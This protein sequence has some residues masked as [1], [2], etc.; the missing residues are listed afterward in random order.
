MEDPK[1]DKY[2][3]NVTEEG[4]PEV[5][6]KDKAMVDKYVQ[7]LTELIHSPKSRDSV[8]NTITSAPDPFDVVPQAA[9]STNDMGVSLMKQNGTEIGFGIQLSASTFLITELIHLGYAA[10]GWEDLSE[11][12][13]AGIYEDTIQMVIERGLADGSIDPIQLQLEVE[14]LLDENQR[15]GAKAFQQEAGV[16]DE[17]SQAAMVDQ[18]V[19]GAV[20]QKEGQ[21]TKQQALSRQKEA[22]TQPQQ[23]LQGGQ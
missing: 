3:Q 15:A 21:M 14:P 7:V 13:F 2:V 5:S 1:V 9:V 8:V 23:A 6:S 19:S 18:Q 10:A 11:E 16:A 20:R 17:P 4:G 12:E 22:Q